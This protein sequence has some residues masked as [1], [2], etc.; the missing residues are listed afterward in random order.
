M[1]GRAVRHASQRCIGQAAWLAAQR[2]V[3]LLVLLLAPAS[4]LAPAGGLWHEALDPHRRVMNGDRQENP[5]S[6][7]PGHRERKQALPTLEPPSCVVRVMDEK[8]YE[9]RTTANLRKGKL[10]NSKVQQRL[11]FCQTTPNERSNTITWVRETQV[12]VSRRRLLR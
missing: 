9:S 4:S 2:A 8:Y 6:E 7:C 3:C 5:G 12:A 1:L 10:N 11:K